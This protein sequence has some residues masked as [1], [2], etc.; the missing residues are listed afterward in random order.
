MRRRSYCFLILIVTSILFVSCNINRESQVDNMNDRTELKPVVHID[1]SI[2]KEL[3][4]EYSIED[5]RSFFD[6]HSLNDDFEENKQLLLFSEV[7]KKYP[8]EI[9]RDKKYAVYKVAQGGFFYVFWIDS[10]SDVNAG[11]K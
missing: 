9:L 5:L 2:Y 1:N 10:F 4:T 11:V 7:D 6:N 3:A 8:V